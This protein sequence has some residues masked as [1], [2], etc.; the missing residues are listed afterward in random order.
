VH[1]AWTKGGFGS[2]VSAM[3]MEKA[4]DW[5]DAPVTRV[6]APDVP[7]PFNDRLE[8]AVIPSVERIVAAVRALY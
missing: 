6:G 2:E 3:V 8:L 4:F 5:L 7:M 1:E